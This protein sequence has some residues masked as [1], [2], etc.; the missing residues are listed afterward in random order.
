SQSIIIVDE[1]HNLPGRVRELLT[2]RLS[3]FMI[4][5]AV[6]EAKRAGYRETLK[7]VKSIGN[8]LLSLLPEN[9]PECIINRDEFISRL[10][11]LNDYKDIIS[12]LRD[13]AEEVIKSQK[14]S[15][16]GAIARFLEV[17]AGPDEG[18]VRIISRGRSRF[19]EF[20]ALSYNCL[21]PALAT[22]GVLREAHSA[23]MMSGTLLP[24]ELYRDILGFG[25][26]VDE[27]VYKSPFPKKNRLALV[28]PLATTRYKARNPREFERIALICASI[29]NFV[30]GNSAVFFPS[31]YLRDQVNRFFSPNSEKTVFLE[32]PGMDKAERADMLSRFAGYAKQGAVLL[33]VVSGS[34]GEGVDFANNL[35]KCVVIVGLPLQQPDLQTKALIDYYD[36]KFSK[37]WDY[38]YVFPAFN[39]ALQS[40]GRCIRSETDRG[41]LVFLDERY[42]WPNYKRCF[43]PD[44]NIKITRDYQ[45]E[46]KGFFNT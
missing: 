33:G 11:G 20:T 45:G 19:G 37:G 39:K 6:K 36:K 26:G 46:V 42:A 4:G 14:E 7:L 23:V 12:N 27:K 38:G 9:V 17:W 8:A 21:D 25:E 44:W 3:T 41:V 32:Q 22:Q 2:E 13:I 18:F 24:T 43:P 35:L 16:I 28:L 34:F 29:V 10:S 31:Y 40:A 15:S 1:A 5:R 30:P